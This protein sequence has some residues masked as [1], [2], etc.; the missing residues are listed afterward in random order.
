MIIE[1][2]SVI[3]TGSIVS[4]VEVVEA[5]PGGK[6]LCFIVE[7]SGIDFLDSAMG[8][9]SV[10]EGNTCTCPVI[11]C[12][13]IFTFLSGDS[14]ADFEI[15][16]FLIPRI[17]CGRIDLIEVLEISLILLVFAV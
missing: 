3:G 11:V 6:H 1:L 17:N 5:V 13:E 12:P 2:G 16:T 8:N 14:I 4:L 10:F 9:L 7:K 15:G